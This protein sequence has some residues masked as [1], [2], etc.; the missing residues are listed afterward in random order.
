MKWFAALLFSLVVAL[1]YRIW[2]SSGGVREVMR[3]DDAVQTQE[4]ANERLATRNRQLAAE[5]RDLKQGYAAIE[6]RARNNLGMVA[7]DETFYQVVT[8]KDPSHEAPM[9]QHAG[10][11]APIP[12][13]PP[14]RSRTRTATAP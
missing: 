13:A 6:E 3:L 9:Q 11:A 8:P 5:V 4:A 1:Q 10:G 2:L 7:V 14:Q 12:L